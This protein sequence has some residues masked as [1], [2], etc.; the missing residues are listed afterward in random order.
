[1]PFLNPID[2]LK[3]VTLAMNNKEKFSYINV[4]KSS[5]VALSRNSENSF[6]PHFAK[7]IISSLRNSDK[8][9]MKA[10]SHTLVSD[11][12]NNRH[13]KIGLHKDARYYYSNIFEY[14]YLN[15]RDVYNT[16]INYYIKNTPKAVISFHDKKN[17]QKY[18]GFNSHVISIP[19]SNYYDRLDYVAD[20]LSEIEKEIDYCVL[21]C[22]IFGLALMSKIWKNLDISIIDLGK[23][24]TLS[25]SYHT[26][27][28]G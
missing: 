25:K 12:D 27:G 21:D 28:N 17:I 24:I 4:P 9:V 16:V 13:H 5:I 3:E 20:Q 7:N 10:I 19:F 8:N 22:G 11:I 14:F 26:Q 18:L 1:M 2:S 6:P 23:T 15:N